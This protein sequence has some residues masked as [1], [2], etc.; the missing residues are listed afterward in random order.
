MPEGP[1]PSVQSEGNY[2]PFLLHSLRG[3]KK[4]N[5]KSEAKVGSTGGS[6]ASFIPKAAGFNK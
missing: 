3:S 2:V 4:T 5:E 1:R 6:I